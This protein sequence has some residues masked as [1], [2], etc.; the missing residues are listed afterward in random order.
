VQFPTFHL[1]GENLLG[2]TN[3]TSI[4]IVPVDDGRHFLVPLPLSVTT[5]FF[6]PVS[7]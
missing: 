7:P 5:R 2:A 3:W 1:Q 6:R 4:A